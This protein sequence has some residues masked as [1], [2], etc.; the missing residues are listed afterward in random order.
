M[1]SDEVIDLRVKTLEDASSKHNELLEELRTGLA[2]IQLM[3][4]KQAAAACPSPGRCLV[5]DAEMQ[6]HKAAA[7][8]RAIR[9]EKRI[10]DMED[11]SEKIDEKF[12]KISG[13]LNRGIGIISV[14]AFVVAPILTALAEYL[15][16]GR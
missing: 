16:K 6:A 7:L 4:A 2:N 8:D 9:S 5:L 13:Q 1:S 12:D 11:W 3:L 10:Q 14:V 15:L